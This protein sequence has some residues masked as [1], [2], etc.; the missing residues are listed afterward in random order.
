MDYCAFPALLESDY[1]HISEYGQGRIAQTGDA[2]D[3][4]AGFIPLL[5]LG[6]T[7][8]INWIFGTRLVVAFSG[9][10]YL[11]SPSLLRLVDIS[12]HILDATRPIFAANTRLPARVTP[13]GSGGK[14]IAADIIYLSRHA[15]T[16][17]LMG[18]TPQEAQLLLDCEVD[19][20]TLHSLALQV[21]QLVPLR[22]QE[23]LLLCK[24]GPYSD[25]NLIA[26]SAYSARLEQ[27]APAD[28]PTP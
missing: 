21:Q 8:S 12:S 7:A 25:E 14:S 11:S 19:F 16:L 1:N 23:T 17:R 26:L 10:V 6:T 18:T 13:A 15:I 27:L 28:R 9:K 4:S 20:L 3:F 22:K 5:P 24:P 2:I